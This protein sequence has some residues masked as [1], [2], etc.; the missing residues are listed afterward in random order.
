MGSDE[1]QPTNAHI[2][3]EHTESQPTNSPVLVTSAEIQPGVTYVLQVL[4]T[5][6][7]NTTNYSTKSDNA[8]A[9]RNRDNHEKL[10]EGAGSCPVCCKPFLAKRLVQFNENKMLCAAG[11]ARQRFLSYTNLFQNIYYVAK[12]GFEGLEF[13][14]K[15]KQVVQASNSTRTKHC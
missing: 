12:C 3:E 9:R 5:D 4:T 1:S 15:R 7:I 13:Q 8:T 10:E 14:H 11:H 2:V 6:E